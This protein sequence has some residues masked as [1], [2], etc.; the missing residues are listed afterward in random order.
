MVIRSKTVSEFED[1]ITTSIESRDKTIDT[2]IGEIRD[3]FV[4]PPS[5]SFKSLHD[6]IVYLSQLTSL[7]NAA[8]FRAEDLDDFVYNECIVRW[9]GSPALVVVTFAR[10]QPPVADIPIP[11]NFPIATI[12]DPETG[13]TLLFR[14]IETRT[15]FGPLTV[16]VSAYYNA[17]SEKYEID[18]ACSS[19]TI[20]TTASVGAYTITQMQRPFPDFDSVYNK[21]ATTPGKGLETQEDLAERYLM[22][23]EGSQISTPLGLARFVLDSFSGALDDYVVYGEN[24]YLTRECDDAGAVDVWLMGEAPLSTYLDIRYPGIETLI[25]LFRQPVSLVTAVSSLGVPY[26]EGVDYEVVTGEGEYSYSN[27]GQDGIRFLAAG[28]H[29]NIDDPLHIEYQYNSLI[30]VITAYY[31]Q[32]KYYTMG[33]DILFRWAQP[34]YIV[35]EADLKV[36]SGNPDSVRSL[37]WDR[38]YKYINGLKLDDDIEEFDIDSEVA[39]VYGVDNWTYITLAVRGGTGV[40]DIIVTPKSYP[41]IDKTDLIINLV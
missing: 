17:D 41:R 37:V 16:P 39:K 26:V 27:R 28:A 11:I 31:R 33:S 12:I 9:S 19:V 1:Q 23:V 36:K 3:L 20:G 4:T 38:V 21:F 40:A 14:T 6:D 22:Q 15:M 30:N 13:E 5:E 32:P 18:V 2:R 7:K 35:L 34:T 25:P 10:I 8:R 29:P 24:A